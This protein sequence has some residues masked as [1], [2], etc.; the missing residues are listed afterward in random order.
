MAEIRDSLSN[1][2]TG[3]HTHTAAVAAGDELLVNGSLVVAINDAAA[4]AENVYAYRGRFS[5][6]KAAV[7]VAAFEAAYWD[8][9]NKV[10]TNVATGNTRCGIFVEAAAAGDAEAVVNINE[11]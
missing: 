4:N 2:R 3:R 5:I 9:T 1:A 10:V 6:A 7:A 8:D 11:N